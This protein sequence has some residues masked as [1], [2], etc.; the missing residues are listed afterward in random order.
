MSGLKLLYKRVKRERYR[1]KKE[2]DI[3]KSGESLLHAH[4]SCV[5]A[6]MTKVWQKLPYLLSIQLFWRKYWR[7]LELL[8]KIK[9]N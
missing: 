7:M 6:E 1:V 4:I 3:N 8:A 2:N 9:Q 5:I